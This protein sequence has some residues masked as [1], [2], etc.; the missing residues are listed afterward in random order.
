LANGAETNW[1]GMEEVISDPT[2]S[3][4]ILTDACWQHIVS[5]HP[6]MNAFR[7]YIVEAIRAPDGVYTGKRAPSR[8]IYRKRYLQVVGVGDSLDLLV[9]VGGADGYVATAYFAAY[10]FRF[11]GTLIWPSN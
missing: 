9:F 5:R 7:Q 2:G 1:N 4:A 3:Q 8:K 6:E 10:A 11:L